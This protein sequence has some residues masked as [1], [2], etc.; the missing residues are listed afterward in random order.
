MVPGTLAL[1]FLGGPF[2]LMRYANHE[3]VTYV[4]NQTHSLFLENPEDTR[5]YRAVVARLKAVTLDEEQS[6]NL[7]ATLA[8]EYDVPEDRGGMAEE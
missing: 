2:E 3:P 6:R 7:L 5:I 8:N 4:E 1:G